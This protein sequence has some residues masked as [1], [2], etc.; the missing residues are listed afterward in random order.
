MEFIVE[1]LQV[2]VQ[3]VM[4]AKSLS[5]AKGA[6]IFAGYTKLL[7]LFVIIMPGEYSSHQ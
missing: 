1:S 2:M 5:H 3:R 6:T 7:P 4:A